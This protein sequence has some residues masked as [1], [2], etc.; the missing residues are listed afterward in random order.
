MCFFMCVTIQIEMFMEDTTV[1]CPSSS[2]SMANIYRTHV[3]TSLGYGQMYVFCILGRN[4][5]IS[6]LQL[7]HIPYYFILKEYK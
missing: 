3:Y 6:G 2:R 4:T 1:Q 7:N 5:F